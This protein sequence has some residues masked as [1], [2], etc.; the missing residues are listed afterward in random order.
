ML[1]I[2]HVTKKYQTRHGIKT[3]LQD[4]S[5]S[6]N[7][8]EKVGI[9]GQNGAGKSTLIKLISGAEQP[10]TGSIDRKMSVSWPLAFSGGFQ[11]SLTGYDNLKFICRV[12]GVDY[13]PLV[14]FIDDFT[15]LGS[16]LRE[17]VKTYSTGMSSRLAFGI[18]MA[19]EF[20]CYL[21]D[22]VLAAGDSRFVE[23]C[24][25]ELFIKRKDRALII[26]SHQPETIK[27]HCN[28]GYVLHRGKLERFTDIDRAYADYTEKQR[29]K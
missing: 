28:I 29:S 10:T 1:G 20:D 26:V 17:P 8:G 25:Q 16:Y 5:F 18:S 2:N 7:P 23:R 22:E 11:G 21:I 6:V 9:L 3:V 12:Y 19:I 15:E 27:R 24:Q 4:I 14:P 13:A